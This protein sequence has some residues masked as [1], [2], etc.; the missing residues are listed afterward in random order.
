MDKKTL[1]NSILEKAYQPEKWLDVMKEYFGAKKFHQK[2]QP[3]SLPSN[4]IA[5]SAVE[6]GSFYTAD[7]RIVGIYEVKLTDKALIERNR[8]GLRN[9][10]KSIIRYDL[11][12]ALIV[13]IQAKK[14]R[15]S[16]V[17][18]IR[19]AEGKKETEPKRYTYLFG[20]GES[21]RTAAER[22]DKLKGKPIYLNDLFEAFS[23]EK[24]NKDF[25]KTYK[26]FYEKFWKYLA[27]HKHYSK[28]LSDK[29]YKD[30]EV[31]REKPIRDFTKK[32]LGRIVFLQFLQ[33][34]GWMGVPAKN[35]DWKGGDIKF[36]QT[37]FAN[38]KNKSVFHSKEL[39]T[40]FFETLNQKRT[41]NIATALLGKDIKIPY[42][43]G[44][45]F[46]KDISYSNDIDFPEDYFAN[47]LDFFE[48]YNFTIDEN[49]PYDS[50]VGID[51]EMLGHIFENL[52]EEN[53]EKGA[54]YTPK[55]IVHYMCQESLI[56]YLHTQLPN[57]NKA[58]FELL[59]RNNQV[60]GAF[61]DYK[62]ANEINN[63][64]KA[65][66]ICDPAIGSGA[67]PMGLLK[68]IFEC[69][70][71]LYGYLKTNEKFDPA[72]IK[73]DIIQQ[74]IYGVDIE[75]G[76][77]EIARLRFW[78]A[79]V[80]D[81]TEP[82]PL[83]NLDY[84]IMQGN[85]L[86]EC[87]ETV[88]LQN[89]INADDDV[90]VEEKKQLTFGHEFEAPN[91]ELTVFSKANKEELFTLIKKYFDP[92][93]WEKQTSEVVDKAVVK[94]QINDFVEGKIHASILK[95]Q[96]DLSKKINAAEKKWEAAGKTDHSKFNQK[97]KEYKQYLEWKKQLEELDA[98]E[99]KLVALQK[100][101]DKPYFLWHL[102]FK[103]V[104][105]KGGFD[106]VI[107]NPPYIQL[108]KEGGKLAQELQNQHYQT[109]ERTGDIYTLF[110]EKGIQLLK[111]GGHLTYITSNKWMRA[112]YGEKTRAF[113]ATYNPIKLIDLGGGIFES[114]TVDTNILIIQK[115]PNQ[116]HCQAADLSKTQQTDFEN[117]TW[118]T[119]KNLGKEAWTIASDIEQRIKAKIEAKGKPLKEWDI[120][121]NY[122]IK[123]GYN[124]A[125]IID[126]KKKDELIAQDPR[127]AEIIKPILRGRDIK[128]YKAD[129]ADLW[130][131]ATFPALKLN[132]D[133]YPAVRD[134]L[135][136]F[137]KKLHQTGEEYIDENGVKQKTRKKTGNKWFETQDQI[138]YYQEFEKEKI[139]YPNMTLFLP[140]IF[141][142][143]GYYTN[144][145]CFIITSEKINLKFL[146]AYFNSKVSHR[147]IRQN[148]PELQ[149]G[150]RE[151]S[152]IFFENIPI[153]PLSE[154]EQ[155]PFVA[156]VEQI[157]SKKEKGEDTTDL[158]Q[159]IDLLV[160]R[161]YELSYEEVKVIDPEF[162][163]SKKAYEAIKLE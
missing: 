33:K 38:S 81:E 44:G 131:I 106:I 80:V 110:Y 22:F 30:D 140:F 70:R 31:K 75:N 115:A 77:V 21:C 160:Y 86:L 57:Y 99:E 128:R 35:T 11:D 141:D 82:Q 23:V 37:L 17:S 126:G 83:P 47:L 113:F 117:L 58:D 121:I 142:D 26:E 107:G 125:F 14:W 71:V 94:R 143:K 87:F 84:K 139:V 3:V 27:A 2:P 120:Q 49:D 24:L 134:Y 52:L 39:R 133:D 16:Y 91:R 46:E 130:L 28:L 124:E 67:F 112:G 138:A 18:E 63:K 163:L 158:E 114:A 161:L 62:T 15:F 13:Y 72:Q 145:K 155:Q 137:G 92:D 34:K 101:D 40:L 65:V 19:T 45:L 29:R 147:W 78:L 10:F 159:Q 132:I 59:V 122:G 104:F 76:A 123:T 43:N 61:A 119:L 129:F 103:D 54:F 95:C 12:A 111:P 69:R 154:P 7:E 9:L 4:E 89:L 53:R 150:T 93:E 135:K 149:G 68:E 36:L 42:L 162:A 148:C 48:Q 146:V 79:L 85:S 127:S 74:N 60:S 153:P 50:E 55:E 151:L 90:M 108:Q 41:N 1:Q 97:S 105:D 156:L 136:S 8:V 109:F 96:R 66:K 100:T 20:E 64:L 98:V 88:D 118:Y 102:W 116:N 73:K 6:L 5:H 157:L 152:K 25:F 32:L 144:Q 56:E 51:P